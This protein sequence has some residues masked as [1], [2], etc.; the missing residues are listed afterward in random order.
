MKLKNK[1]SRN[2]IGIIQSCLIFALVILVIF[3]MIQ[4]NRLQGTARVINYAGL[5]RG[6]TQREV[7]LEITG[8]QNDELIKYL[9]DILSGLKYQDGNYDLVK[10]QDK[11]YQD[12]L[13][14]QIDYWNKI[15]KEIEAVRSNG[16]ENTDIVNMSETYFKMADDTVSAAE[17]YSEK[18][19]TKIRTIE[20]LSVLDML[21][22]VILIIV[23][24]I[25][26]MK[27]A[28]QNKLLDR[29]SDSFRQATGRRETSTG[30][31]AC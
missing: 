12:K 15:K 7:K 21:C 18:I 8:S 11:E 2:I 30:T 10:L 27:M 13:Q 9:D 16:Y 23:Q 25:M 20:L 28:R 31:P 29:T 19:A 3:M 17:N 22:L 24:T 4:I 1:K 26:A 6:A 14:V 5:V